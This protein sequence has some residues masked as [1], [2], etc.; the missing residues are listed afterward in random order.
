[1]NRDAAAYWVARSSRAMTRVL[2]KYSTNNNPL[3]EMASRAD[4]R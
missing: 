4:A 3:Y 2:E 1:M